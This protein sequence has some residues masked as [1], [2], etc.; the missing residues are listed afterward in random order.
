MCPP[1]PYHPVPIIRP[2]LT[3]ELTILGHFVIRLSSIKN[4]DASQPIRY[5]TAIHKAAVLKG[6][7]ELGILG[8]MTAPAARRQGLDSVDVQIDLPTGVNRFGNEKKKNGVEST[9]EASRRLENSRIEVMARP[10]SAGAEL[11]IRDHGCGIPEVELTPIFNPFFS[12]HQ[13]GNPMGLGPGMCR[14]IM[15]E[16]GGSIEVESVRGAHPAFILVFPGARHR[17][18][19]PST[20]SQPAAVR[21]FSS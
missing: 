7:A 10:V 3:E 8:E 17:P 1:Y 4:A 5:L 11:R 14:K 16:F 18:Q 12:T 20:P 21:K 6:L 2:L 9:E 19:D 15:E 13:S